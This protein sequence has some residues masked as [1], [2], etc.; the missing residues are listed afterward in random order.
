MSRT[1]R[2]TEAPPMDLDDPSPA[3]LSRFDEPGGPSPFDD[4]AAVFD[5]EIVTDEFAEWSR[6]ADYGVEP[7]TRLF[8]HVDASGLVELE[9]CEVTSKNPR[10]RRLAD[11]DSS[12]IRIPVDDVPWLIERLRRVLL[13]HEAQKDGP[14]ACC[15]EFGTGSG[16]HG[17]ECPGAERDHA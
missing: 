6:E 2:D 8:V 7:P 12:V 17:D 16:E 3:P 14:A 9:I 4:D 1:T 10:A 15:G 13:R 11:G 5:N